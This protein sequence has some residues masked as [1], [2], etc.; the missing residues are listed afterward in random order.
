MK[1]ASSNTPGQMAAMLALS[2]LVKPFS[3]PFVS[4]SL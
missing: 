3:Q 4:W 2:A 1:D